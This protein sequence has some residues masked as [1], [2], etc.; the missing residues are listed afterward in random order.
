VLATSSD[1]IWSTPPELGR[2]LG[3]DANKILHW[4]ASG[5]LEA[6]NFASK[7]NGRPRWKVSAQALDEFLKR[8]AAKVPPKRQRRPRRV[9]VEAGSNFF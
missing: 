3:V 2:R 4:I 9:A 1:S 8:R 5:Q 6:A 7:P